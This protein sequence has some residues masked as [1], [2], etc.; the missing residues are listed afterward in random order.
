MVWHGQCL[1]AGWKIADRSG[2]GVN[3]SRTLTAMVWNEHQ[4]P[5]FIGIFIANSKLKTLPELKPSGSEY[6]CKNF[7]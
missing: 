6:Q 1:R 4:Q 7:Q 5:L 3:G 2:G